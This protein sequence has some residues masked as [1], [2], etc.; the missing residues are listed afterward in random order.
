MRLYCQLREPITL[1]PVAERLT[2]EL[3]LHGRGLEHLPFRLY[4]FL[5]FFLENYI[6]FSYAYQCDISCTICY[7]TFARINI[8]VFGPRQN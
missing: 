1:S 5:V 6:L 3:S 2:E 7:N 4:L 8:Q